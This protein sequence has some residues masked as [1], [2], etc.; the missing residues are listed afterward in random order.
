MSC[1]RVL[2]GS[3]LLA[4]F[5]LNA[6]ILPAVL[7]DEADPA[8]SERSIGQ[9]LTLAREGKT[10]FAIVTAAEPT[11][12]EQTAATW[13]SETLE[14]VTGVSGARN[15]SAPGLSTATIREPCRT[16]FTR[17]GTSSRRRSLRLNIPNTFRWTP[18]ANG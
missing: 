12:E 11:I 13:L 3:I 2:W 1:R 7:A 8:M 6:S 14:Q 16:E 18:Q 4:A 15:T 5:H 9:S 17:L 10:T